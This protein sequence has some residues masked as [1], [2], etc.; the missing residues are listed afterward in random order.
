VEKIIDINL[1]VITSAY[2]EEEKRATFVSRRFESYLIQFAKRF[3]YGLNLILVLGLVALGALGF[4]P[5]TLP[6]YS[7]GTSKRAF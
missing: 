4:S 7:K 6:I 5:M 1:D 2:V 3:S